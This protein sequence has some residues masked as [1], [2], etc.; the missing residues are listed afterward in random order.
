MHWELIGNTTPPSNTLCI[1]GRVVSKT[2]PPS[3]GIYSFIYDSDKSY[4]ISNKGDKVECLPYDHWCT[5][6]DIVSNVKD[7]IIDE[8]KFEVDKIKM[9]GPFDHI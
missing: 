3:I 8:L 5:V 6:E 1:V 7:R 4:W 2:V 9:M